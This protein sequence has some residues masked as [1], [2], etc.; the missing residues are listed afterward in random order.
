MPRLTPTTSPA[1]KP[2]PP[3]RSALDSSL[4]VVK[5]SPVVVSATKIVQTMSEPKFSEVVSCL[6]RVIWAAAAGNLQLALNIQTGGDS[7]KSPSASSDVSNKNL[8]IQQSHSARFYLGRR[9]SRGSST[10]S[11]GSDGSNST[12]TE[13]SSGLH[14]GVCSQQ[15]SGGVGSGDAQIAGEAFDLLV[16][17]LQMRTTHITSL[18]RL[19]VLGD[20]IVET[21]LG[22]PS[23]EV[24]QKARD[25]LIRL[26]KLKVAARCLDLDSDSA[27]SSPS[28]LT[29][30]Q[31]LTKL[32]LKTPVPL[33]IPACSARGITHSLLAQCTEYFDL[34]SSL[35]KGLSR[36]EQQLLEEDAASMI[37]DELTFLHNFAVGG[38]G[39]ARQQ[40]LDC[41][42]LA[43][44][45]KLV[46]ALLTCEGVNKKLVGATLIPEVLSSFLFPASRL[47]LEESKERT[48]TLKQRWSKDVNPKCDTVQSREAAYRVLV[49]LSR[50]CV[51][52]LSLVTSELVR[53]HHSFREDLVQQFDYSPAVERRSG[54]TDDTCG[55]FVGLKNAGATCYMNSVLQQLFCVPGVS[56]QLLLCSEE[57]EEESVFYQLQNVFGH[58]LESKLKYYEP[59][60][61][62]HCFRLFGQPV[63]VRE[64]QDAF[65][66]FMQVLLQH[67]IV[68]FSCLTKVLSSSHRWWTRWTSTWCQNASPSYLQ[69]SFRAFSRTRKSARGVHIATS[70]RRPSWLSTSP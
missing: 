20:F 47:I 27:T 56:R 10:G 36:R 66:F 23:E 12:T 15:Q 28:N 5:K 53:M 45:F 33:W 17:C 70:E 40:K 8:P 63:N 19:S 49:E 26:S 4:S 31:Q 65:E 25:Q 42:L 18:F 67:K 21:V 34:R 52:N 6:I 60:R 7:V 57:E 37:E 50:C 16:T 13:N 54:G 22:S 68:T 11:S 43:G 30:K 41:P 39:N 64:Q 59:E 35:L 69:D 32:L 44:H 48:R 62:W 9:R 1:M 24:R 14:A 51:S 58:L 55:G 38:G 46:E 2:T 3:K 61:F 29:P